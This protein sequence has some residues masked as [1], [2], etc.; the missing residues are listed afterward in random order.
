MVWLNLG[1]IFLFAY[2]LYF[3]FLKALKDSINQLSGT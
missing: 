3:E 1:E 2:F